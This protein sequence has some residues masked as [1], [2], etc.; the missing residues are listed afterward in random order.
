[1]TDKK[2][3]VVPVVALNAPQAKGKGHKV[4]NRNRFP[5]KNEPRKTP[6]IRSPEQ[7]K[8]TK[9]FNCNKMG[10]VAPDCSEPKNQVNIQANIQ[11]MKNPVSG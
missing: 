3:D 11:L 8:T 9:C 6:R 7:L 2:S 4:Q 10:H 5:N 1:M